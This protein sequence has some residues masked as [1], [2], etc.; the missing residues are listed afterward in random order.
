MVGIS[1]GSRGEEPGEKVC[2]KRQQQQQQQQHNNNNNN[3]T[4]H[5]YEHVPK[6]VETTQGGRSPYCGINQY[7]RTELFLT[8]S[9]IL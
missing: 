3:D 4:K 9:Q 2:D 6:P 7:E 1:D 8:I 5:R